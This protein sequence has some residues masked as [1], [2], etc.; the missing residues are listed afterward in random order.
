[1]KIDHYDS[2]LLTWEY[3]R[4]LLDRLTVDGMSSEDDSQAEVDG[5]TIHIFRVKFV[6]W[7]APEIKTYL[8]WI[9]AAAHNAALKHLVG[10]SNPWMPSQVYSTSVVF[11]LPLNMYN[12]SWLT[13]MQRDRP[14]WVEKTLCV[15]RE[16]FHLLELATSQVNS[17]I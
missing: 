7:R 4:D 5:Q 17:H 15:S 8:N 14:A 12:Q 9:D 11:K 13:S 3:L 2:D 16:V 1:M 10:T 6:P